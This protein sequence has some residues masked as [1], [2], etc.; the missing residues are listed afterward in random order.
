MKKL[1][2]IL[3]PSYNHEKYIKF[4]IDSLLAQTN[5]NWEL[6]IVDDCSTDN[7]V[8]EIQ[9]YNDK[10]IKLIKNPFNTGINYTLNT[11]FEHSKGDIVVCGASDDVFMNDF[12]ENILDAF[13]QNPDTD[14]IYSDLKVMN[15]NGVIQKNEIWKQPRCDKNTSLRR[16]FFC[17]NI[18]LSPSMALRR[19]SFSK[20][21][22]LPIPLSQHQD[23]KMHIDV[24]LN[25]K[26]LVIDKILIVYRKPSRT[27]GMSVHNSKTLRTRQL[28][29]N[30]VMD[31]FLQITDV[32]KL[33]EIFGDDLLQ[34]FGVLEN[35]FI[36]YYLGM[37]ALDAKTEYKKL[38]G[39]NQV[40]K[41][42]TNPENYNLLYEKYGFCYK[43]FL[44]LADNFKKT[45]IEKKY[46]KYKN[47]FNF[48]IIVILV[49]LIVS[50]F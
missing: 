12:V 22:P 36:P 41:F 39:Y 23:Y 50:I 33:R 19:D 30:I 34:R 29:E 45:T 11:A 28:E 20:I 44:D 40:V 32:A 37:L 17:S 7:N 35:K 8:A 4:F 13:E 46:K 6:I 3:C 31:S 21:Y 9:K 10:R 16:M 48:S 38:W 42:I 49:L 1:V 26:T 25:L 14:V 24:A 43:D 18:M 15:H 2:S 27:S 47:L 5:P